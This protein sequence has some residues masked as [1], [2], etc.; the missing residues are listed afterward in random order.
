MAGMLDRIRE[1]EGFMAAAEGTI[2]S[3]RSQTDQRA[4]ILVLGAGIVGVTCAL[5]LQRRGLT[6]TLVDKRAPGQETSYGNGGVLARSSLIPLNNPSLPSTLP[7]L[8]SNRTPQL[9]YNPWFLIKNFAWATEFLKSTRR[10][11]FDETTTSLDA[12]IRL[13]IDEHRRLMQEAGVSHRLR[14]TGWIFLYRT[15]AAFDAALFSREIFAQFSVKTSPLSADELHDLEPSVAPLFERSLWVNDAFSVDSPG[16]IVDAYVK[17]FSKRGGTVVNAEIYA[18]RPTAD[19]Y[20]LAEH[21]T[22]NFQAKR[23]VIALGPWAKEFLGRLGVD[24][25]M[26]YE[27]GYHQHF[28]GQTGAVLNRPIYDTANGYILTPMEQGIR[29]TTGVELTE[30][31]ARPNYSQL[32]AGQRAAREVFPLGQSLDAVPWLG[33]RPTLPDSRPMIGEIAALGCNGL[34]AAFGH[35]HIGF[36]TSAGTAAL[37][38]AL[39]FNEPAPINSWAF[40]PDR[41][42]LK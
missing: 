24:V 32:E 3:M 33:S 25:P 15:E 27:R 29:L 35:Q 28:E 11:V 1:V 18:L 13:S 9:R 6:V 36:S 5:E 17:L 26:A 21:A 19:G 42:H 31:F 14:E 30:Q 40:R 20:W 23:V 8:L 34:W 39:M 12:L 7:K 38:G 22:G 41:F 4:D 10:K 2:D 37:L 16:K